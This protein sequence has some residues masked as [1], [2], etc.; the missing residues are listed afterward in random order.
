MLDTR[1]PLG[2]LKKKLGHTGIR[3]RKQL[4]VGSHFNLAYYPGTRKR[5]VEC[6]ANYTAQLAGVVLFYECAWELAGLRSARLP[7]SEAGR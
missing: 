2:Y 4:E 7:L 6:W 3:T 5:E 1:N